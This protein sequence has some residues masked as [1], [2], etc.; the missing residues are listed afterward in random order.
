MSCDRRRL[1]VSM[2]SPYSRDFS[3]L[4]T[5]PRRRNSAKTRME[6]SGVRSSCDTLETNSFFIRDSFISREAVRRARSTPPSSTAASA[7][8]RP[9]FSRKLRRATT[10]GVVWRLARP[11]F[12]SVKTGEN[13]RST[14]A[15]RACPWSGPVEKTIRP[16]PSVTETMG[17]SSPERSASE[18]LIAAGSRRARK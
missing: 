9:T 5:R 6:A 17:S 15:L 16:L 14:S 11:I 12:Q 1:S 13:D 4:S 8:E 18:R 7:V 10:A 3:G 2:Y